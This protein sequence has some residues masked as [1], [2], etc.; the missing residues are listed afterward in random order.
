VSIRPAA[1]LLMMMLGA[2]LAHAG[3][4]GPDDS[5][6]TAAP[7]QL[8]DVRVEGAERGDTISLHV[9]GEVNASLRS[10]R[11]GRRLTVDLPQTHSQ[12]VRPALP[13]G[14]RLLSEMEVRQ[15]RFGT[16]RSTRLVIDFMEAAQAELVTSPGLVQIMVRPAES[17]EMVSLYLVS[18]SGPAS[19]E[20][21]APPEQPGGDGAAPE[22]AATPAG[23]APAPIG[24]ATPRPSHNSAPGD[25]QLGPLDLLQ[26][27]VLGVEELD[28]RT[29]IAV[30]GTL[31][32]PLIGPVPAAGLTIDALERD[33]ARRL[34]DGYVRDP[35]VSVFVEEFRSRRMSVSGAVR[36]PGTF[37]ILRPTTLLEAL[38]LA[39]GVLSEEAA[40]RVQ[41]VRPA[42]PEPIEIDRLALQSGQLERNLSIEPGDLVHVPFDEMLEVL[43][44]GRVARPDHYRVRRSQN[45]TVLRAVMLAGGPSEGTSGRRVEVLRRGAGDLTQTR[46]VN[47]NR[48]R[49]G[50]EPDL[51]LQPDDIVVVR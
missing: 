39:G 1:G 2:A 28:R 10:S 19:L 51:P 45:L 6:E 7:V 46:V 22:A 50:K 5:G 36:A 11:D 24:D 32:L 18:P 12:I 42:R 13:A 33:I 20:A 4:R 9:S 14:L 29:R 15:T 35:Q 31:N 37:E 40:P 47:L 3:W 16:G 26:V 23:P 48:I 8:T 44:Q 25:A 21:T 30:D 41:I 49:E 34:A 27:K 17:P 43:V 38:T